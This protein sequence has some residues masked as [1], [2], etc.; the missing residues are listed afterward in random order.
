MG[1][2]SSCGGGA[3]GGVSANTELRA[4]RTRGL[5][6]SEDTCR[7]LIRR[8]TNYLVILFEYLLI[9]SVSIS[10]AVRRQNT[11]TSDAYL[12]FPLLDAAISQSIEGRCVRY[13]LAVDSSPRWIAAK[14]SY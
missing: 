11:K 8:N 1:S 12:V 13:I 3:A 9:L 2:E 4:V 5:E 10:D 6:T 7:V 14:A